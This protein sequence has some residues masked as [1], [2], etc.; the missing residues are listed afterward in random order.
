MA[1]WIPWLALALA[2]FLADQFTK[3]LILGYYQLG[4]ST[5]VTS[6][7]PS[8]SVRVVRSP[9]RILVPSRPAPAPITATSKCAG[10]PL[11]RI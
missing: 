6:G 3:V 4:D 1:R 9:S 7:S 10:D 5:Y 11:F 8:T 2:V